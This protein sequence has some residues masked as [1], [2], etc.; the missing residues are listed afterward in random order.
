MKMLGKIRTRALHGLILALTGLLA[1]C[2]E[3]SAEQYVSNGKS[4][5]EKGDTRGAAIEFK[6]AL[7]RDATSAEARF[8]FASSLLRLG[9]SAGAEVEFEKLEKSGYDNNL[10]APLMARAMAQ[11]GKN[12]ALVAKYREL[13]L[14]K[15]AAMSE[16]QV[17]LGR[18]YLSMD[19][20]EDAK[21]VEKKALDATPTMLE[22]L[23]LQARI[24]A[25]SGDIPGALTQTKHLLE[26]FPKEASTWTM[27]GDM[28]LATGDVK[29]AGLSYQE[30]IK[31]NE[32]DIQPYFS[33]M[34]VL[35]LSGDLPAAAANQTTL[36]RLD[37][38]HPLTLYFR[39]WLKMEQGDLKQAQEVALSLLKMSPENVDVLYLAG[40]IEVRRN[41]LERAVDYLGKAVGL[42]PQQVRPRLLLANTQLRRGEASRA[43]ATLQP[44]LKV[45]KPSAD[46]LVLAAAASARL[47]EASDKTEKLLARAVE[48]DPNNV[49]ARVG[50]AKARIDRGDLAWGVRELR[51]VG[52][53]TQDVSPDV[54]LIEVLARAKRFDDAFEALK[55][56]EAKPNGKVVAD[57]QRGRIELQR[58]NIPQ[59]REAFDAA[60][61]GNANHIPAIAALASLDI[62]GNQPDK[63]RER[64]QSVLDKDPGNATARAA[65]L[66]LS[67]DR[68]ASN[69]ELI[70]MAQKA[71]KAAPDSRELRVDLVRLTLAK[72]D[73]K[74]A[75][76]GAQEAL[77]LLGEDPE[78]LALLGQAQLATDDTNLAVTTFSKLVSMRPG[79]P[80]SYLLL[81]AA[82]KKRGDFSQA[83]QTLRR[84]I[85]AAP[86]Y[87]PL[88]QTLTAL[89]SGNAQYPQALQTAKQWQARDKTGW[90]GYSLEGDVLLR[91]ERYMAAAEAYLMGAAKNPA[92][93]LAIRAHQALKL[94]G[95]KEAA[96]DFEAKRLA[97]SPKDLQFVN[98]LGETAMQEGHYATSES[99]FRKALELEPNNP[100]ILNNLAWVLGKQ[101][102]DAAAL[103]FSN[104]AIQ[105]APKQPTFLDTRAELQAR[106][107]RLDDAIETQ[108]QA[109]ALSPGTPLHRLHLAAFLVTA[110]KKA[111]A[112]EELVRLAQAGGGAAIQAEV[113][114]LQDAL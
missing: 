8:M 91:Q 20:I 10:V 2:F 103:E 30:A 32:N 79:L 110:G 85:E 43:M 74:Q 29:Q 52:K 84:G 17:V 72:P 65:L 80:Q 56:L 28:Q 62:S 46:V 39:S 18:T 81:A 61:K 37:S 107:G 70:A 88:Y 22:A 15:S 96:A 108:R 23:Q 78:L 48:A 35:L 63:A 25:L 40:T 42:A 98:Y 89:Q 24:S 97:A 44:L 26:K 75:A 36:E 38:K 82:Y 7:Q 31:R 66:R 1:G 16:L 4:R 54:L 105:L 102:K 99:R 83:V 95:K 27:L 90:L 9:D 5:L 100:A 11:Q 92:P 12:A 114:R 64:F 57:M 55:M 50:L 41:S 6:N 71:V 13:V 21:S 19:R 49:Q 60:L 87:A 45:E 51:D 34:P 101:R 93:L 69:D 109:V 76:E 77:N 68:G 94:A 14:P 113:K 58:A 33:L 112:K 67:M 106:L 3:P 104:K 73:P 47:G 59:A 86:D 111:D 53:A